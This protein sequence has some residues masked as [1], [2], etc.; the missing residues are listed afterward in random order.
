MAQRIRFYLD[1]NLPIAVATQL[2]RRGIEAVTVR[3]LGFLGDSDSNHLARSTRLGYV[4]CT[5]DADYV[6]LDAAS[7]EHSGII[8]GQQHKHGIGDWVR[9][10]ELLA[11]VL[12]PEDMQNR[13]E[14]LG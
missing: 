5:N 4:L 9:F 14:Y 12:D 6:N 7:A 3:D 2:H 10:L 8:F 1:E 11:S 13:V